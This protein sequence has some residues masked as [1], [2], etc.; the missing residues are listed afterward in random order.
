MKKNVFLLLVLIFC[1]Y[2]S[3]AFSQSFKKGNNLIRIGIGFPN[4]I[5]PSNTLVNNNYYGNYYG[6]LWSSSWGSFPVTFTYEYAVSDYFSIGAFGA[7]AFYR[8]SY[9]DLLDDNI[10]VGYDNYGFPIYNYQTYTL[11]NT[12][13]YDYF[14]IAAKGSYHFIKSDRFD[15]YLS[16][17]LGYTRSSYKYSFTTDDPNY[18]NNSYYSYYYS[19]VPSNSNNSSD[20]AFIDIRIGTTW[21]ILKRFGLFA[22][23]GYGLVP[24]IAG[25][26]VKLK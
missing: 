13:K 7:Y 21:Y 18:P 11:T 22:E 1:I 19:L 20:K 3:D 16:M 4:Y 9:M 10:I 6:Y 26:Q 17:A 15:P 12:W 14:V 23:V 2:F 5:P 24:A 25:L 8:Q